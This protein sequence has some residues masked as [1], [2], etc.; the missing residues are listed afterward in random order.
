MPNEGNGEV[1]EVTSETTESVV[2]T[3]VV[4]TQ[5]VETKTFDKDYVDSLRSESASWRTKLREKED[6]LTKIQARLK[7]FEDSKLTK[8]EKLAQ[9]LEE[10]RGRASSFEAQA[11]EKSLALDL[12]LAARDAKITDVKAAVKLA[13]RELIQYDDSGN[14]MNLSEVIGNLQSEYP[15]LFGNAAP[16]VPS[17]GVTNPAKAPSAPKYTREDLKKMSPARIVELQEKGE[18]N[19]ILGG[20]R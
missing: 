2:E 16:S 6:A 5:E 18:L 11:R 14:V 15:S 12:A 17:P 9:D 4:E 20:G 13:D 1:T 10:Y 19:H 3:P 8:D 7:E